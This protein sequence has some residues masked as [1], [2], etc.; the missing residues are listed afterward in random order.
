MEKKSRTQTRTSSIGRRRRCRQIARKR[1]KC[2]DDEE[3]EEDALLL[4]IFECVS[5][6]KNSSIL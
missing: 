1:D 5:S 6:Y 4:Y 2:D 3:E